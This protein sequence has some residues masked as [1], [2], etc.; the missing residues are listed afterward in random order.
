MLLERVYRRIGDS[1]EETPLYLK[2]NWASDTR[3]HSDALI[4]EVSDD[5]P[6][7]K[8]SCITL[9][10]LSTKNGKIQNPDDI[11]GTYL[12]RG[13]IESWKYRRLKFFE[14]DWANNILSFN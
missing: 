7:Y 12:L 13:E 2:S 9:A 5:L 8:Q 4:A 14:S 10:G 11:F 1:K 6:A 3:C